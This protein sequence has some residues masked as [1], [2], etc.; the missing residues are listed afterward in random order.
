MPYTKIK[1]KT[2]INVNNMSIPIKSQALSYYVSSKIQI[3]TRTSKYKLI[4]KEYRLCMAGITDTL[5][6]KKELINVDD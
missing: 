4:I 5:M 2:M 6:M 1:N 3:K